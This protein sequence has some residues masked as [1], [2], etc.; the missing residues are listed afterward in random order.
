MFYLGCVNM[1][2]MIVESVKE[3]NIDKIIESVIELQEF[4]IRRYL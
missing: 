1:E 2:K 4:L 3:N